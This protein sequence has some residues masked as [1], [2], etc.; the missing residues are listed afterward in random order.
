V[1]SI[2]KKVRLWIKVFANEVL[3]A[4]KQKEYGDLRKIIQPSQA[5]EIVELI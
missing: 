4:L 2:S 5:P 1:P 3:R